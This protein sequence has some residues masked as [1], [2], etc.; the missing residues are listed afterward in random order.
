MVGARKQEPKERS[1]PDSLASQTEI[2]P[3]LDRNTVP[4]R[5]LHGDAGLPT[6]PDLP[7]YRIGWLYVVLTGL[8]A[9][10]ALVG[11]AWLGFCGLSLLRTRRRS[12]PITEGEIVATMQALSAVYRVRPPQLLASERV[13]SPFLTGLRRPAILL[14]AS[15]ASEFDE[16]AQR[17]ILA[18]ELMHLARGDC[19]WNLL[20][21]LLG[22]L[23]WTQP[24]LWL[25]CRR[26]EQAAE[27]VC[28]QAVLEQQCAP[29]AY[30]RCLLAL[31]ERLARPR[32]ERIAGVGMAAFRSS[33]GRR[34]ERILKNA[35][36]PLLPFSARL[37]ASIMVGI[38]GSAV[39]CPALLSAT[40]A[41]SLPAPPR[42]AAPAL[43]PLLPP[44]E[45]PMTAPSPP[46]LS[47]ATRAPSDLLHAAE[48][49]PLRTTRIAAPAPRMAAL[50]A[51][52]PPNQKPMQDSS[53]ATNPPTQ[54]QIKRRR[55]LEVKFAFLVASGMQYQQRLAQEQTARA[56]LAQIANAIAAQ[57]TQ[58]TAQSSLTAQLRAQLA[59]SRAALKQ[60]Q[61]SKVQAL[62]NL[63]ATHAQE[64][65]AT[66]QL[67]HLEAVLAAERTIYTDK[68]P[69]VAQILAEL[70]TAQ[71]HLQQT[72][73]AKMAA[74]SEYRALHAQLEAALSGT[75]VTPDL[76]NHF[77]AK[78]RDLDQKLQILKADATPLSNLR[79]TPAAPSP[80]QPLEI[81]IDPLQV[82]FGLHRGDEEYDRV[83]GSYS[84]S[85]AS[86]QNVRVTI[87]MMINYIDANGWE[88]STMTIP[89]GD[90]SRVTPSDGSGEMH[91][92]YNCN[93]GSLYFGPRVSK[94]AVKARYYYAISCLVFDHGATG[95]KKE[96][97][98]RIMRKESE[99]REV[100]LKSAPGATD[101]D[102]R[103]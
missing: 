55:E 31:A 77:K 66:K 97:R 73:V 45:R 90:M 34:V 32:V 3:E 85:G 33:L 100:L 59:T 92:T 82:Q 24:L 49:L 38:V 15:Y 103:K 42:H 93:L 62:A 46:P 89:V 96:T 50:P 80:S 26:L 17:A 64:Q 86:G 65:A 40:A 11:L 51:P 30:A 44:M 48:S 75:T 28:D 18:H 19:E 81:K 84:I 95:N 5:P 87:S 94:K 35:A 43:P 1:K 61:L 53:H 21:R 63:A 54:Q 4:I 98:V 47:S 37:R 79:D 78:L 58:S 8:W 91:F 68:D 27:E 71:A 20:A 102:P 7:I 12:R 29:E 16:A 57:R 9:V 99:T 76:A 60:V 25:L 13:A 52:P 70:A 72:E 23:G 101:S 74:L 2:L 56:Q 69:R 83:S 41:P 6:A 88:A 14:P 36:P 10:G 67:A 22:A 39:C